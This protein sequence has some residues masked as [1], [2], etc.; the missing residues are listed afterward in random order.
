MRLP[1]LALIAGPLIASGCAPRLQPIDATASIVPA[2]RWGATLAPNAEAPEDLSARALVVPGQRGAESYVIISLVGGTP[3]WRYPWH[4]H[5][6]HCATPGAL[7]GEVDDYDPLV[8]RPDGNGQAM[9]TLPVALPRTGTYY[10]DLHDPIDST[11]LACGNLTPDQTRL[12]PPSTT[13]DP[14]R[15]YPRAE[16]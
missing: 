5:T 8:I 7:L 15:S 14:A 10:V 13:D 2:I 3:R 9:A 1:R 6:G 16:P 4:L 11:V 12:P